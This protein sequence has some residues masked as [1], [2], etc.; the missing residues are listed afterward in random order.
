M[1]GKVNSYNLFEGFGLIISQMLLRH[2]APFNKT[3]LSI[4]SKGSGQGCIVNF[5]IFNHL[6]MREYSIKN[7]Y[8]KKV[9]KNFYKS[10]IDLKLSQG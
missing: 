3:K 2:I 5:K 1:I 4:Y 7:S 6:S 10:N 9:I 8:R